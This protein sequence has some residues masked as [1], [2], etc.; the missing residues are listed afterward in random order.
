VALK[1]AIQM[2][3]TPSRCLDRSVV[4]H[5]LQIDLTPGRQENG[6]LFRQLVQIIITPIPVVLYHENIMSHISH[7]L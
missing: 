1:T 5:A 4:I 2:H 6:Y 7:I 3:I